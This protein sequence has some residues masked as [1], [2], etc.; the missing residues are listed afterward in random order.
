MIYTPNTTPI[1]CDSNILTMTDTVRSFY[2][3]YVYYKWQRS[4][5][6]GVNWVDVTAPAGP[7][8]PY[9][10]G[11]EWEYVSTYI[12]PPAE[13]QAANNGDMYR[14]VTSTTLA[15]LTDPLCSF[16]DQGSIV[17]IEVI[18]CD[19]PLAAKF[20]RFTGKIQGTQHLLEWTTESENEPLIFEVQKSTDGLHF[21]LIGTVNGFNNISSPSNNYSFTNM[22]TSGDERVYYRI[23]MKNLSGQAT[24]SRIILLGNDNR[25]LM[26]LS[27][28]SP[29]YSHLIFDVLI[30]RP[31]KARWMPPEEL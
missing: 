13:T 10:N 6:G 4:T 28:I 3:N 23:V 25:P 7:I 19:V 1:V 2:N 20:L 17:T 9:W 11:T 14:L 15:N 24:I 18:D 12:V 29:F 8:V 21:Q 27:V 31:G 16:T 26:F 22:T 30:T 5:D